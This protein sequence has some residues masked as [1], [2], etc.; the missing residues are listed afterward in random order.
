MSQ[1]SAAVRY[2]GFW[3][4]AIAVTSASARNQL[5]DDAKMQLSYRR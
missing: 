1:G 3:W 4:A 2:V 5:P